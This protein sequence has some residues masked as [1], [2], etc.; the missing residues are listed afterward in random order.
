M[1]IRFL[2][3]SII[4]LVVGFS[5]CLSSSTAAEPELIDSPS[6]TADYARAEQFIPA[7]AVASMFNVSVD[8]NWI[9]GTHSFWYLKTGRNGQEFIL[10]DVQNK[11]RIPAFNHTFLA[12]SLS[13]AVD[14]PVDPANLPFSEITMQKGSDEIGFIAFNRTMQF[15]LRSGQ[16]NDVPAGLEAGPGESISPDGRLAAFV[17]DHNLCIRDTKTGEIYQLTEDGSKDYAY[18]ERSETVSHPVSQARLND[19][20]NPYAVWSPDS[21]RIASLRM[22]Q[23]NVTQMHLLQYVPGNG[24]R[25]Q[26]WTYR[27]ALPDDALVPMYEPIVVDVLLKKVVPVS[28]K[29]QPEVSLMDTEDDVL[30]WWSDDCQ[31][32]YSLYAERGET[33]LELLKTDPRERPNRSNAQ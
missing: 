6:A 20:P 29:A 24:S 32:L 23:R 4:F 33:A 26:L 16:I 10:V 2:R 18:A 1:N 14:E 17:R 12:E 25:P 21:R 3:M 19:T 13:L 28:Y 8:P 15:N 31:V 30:Q 11:T 9:A 22:D 27:F 7:N 5:I